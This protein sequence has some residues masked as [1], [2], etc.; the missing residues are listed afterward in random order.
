MLLPYPEAATQ[1]KGVR[2]ICSKFIGEH[3]CRSVIS[4]KLQSSFIE[5]TLQHRC[6][7]VNL[8]HVFRTPFT[9][10]T[11]GWLLLLKLP[12][13][14]L[15]SSFFIWGFFRFLR[16]FFIARN[17]L[18]G[19]AWNIVTCGL[20]LE[21]L[22]GMLDKLQKHIGH[23]LTASLEPLAYC[24][25]VATLSLFYRVYFTKCLYELAEQ[26]PLSYCRGR[27]TLYCNR[28]HNFSVAI[29]KC[30]KDIYVNNVFPPT[31]GHWNSFR[32]LTII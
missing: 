18:Y 20:V 16:M 15:E 27:S 23:L 17:L 24:R 32:I 2:K 12:P 11:S 7:P 4:I 1:V 26:V 30:Y 28:L 25:I 22:I 31:V 29:L 5:I 6:S 10:N 13:T 8:V 19:L 21:L 9:K 14:K 3:P